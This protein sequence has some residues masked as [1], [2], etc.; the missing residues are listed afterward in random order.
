M[1]KIKIYKNKIINQYQIAML[2]MIMK[3][4]IMIWNKYKIIKILI[5]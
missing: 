4:I 1:I 5:K 3:I 2:K